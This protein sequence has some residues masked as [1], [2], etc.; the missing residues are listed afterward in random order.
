M[1]KPLKTS[2]KYLSPGRNSKDDEVIRHVSNC[3][4]RFAALAGDKDGYTLYPTGGV[5][6]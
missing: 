2:K 4:D 1:Y 5:H 3:L 6:T